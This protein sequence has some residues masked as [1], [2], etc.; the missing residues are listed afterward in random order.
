MQLSTR[1]DRNPGF[2]FCRKMYGTATMIGRREKIPRS[3]QGT[4]PIAEKQTAA[5]ELHSKNR[6]P[7]V[8]AIWYV[9]ADA[10]DAQNIAAII[11]NQ[12]RVS[13]LTLQWSVPDL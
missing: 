11:K 6:S 5:T 7:R 13:N 4:M 12:Y 3:M 8:I 1:M 10:M 9:H 2:S